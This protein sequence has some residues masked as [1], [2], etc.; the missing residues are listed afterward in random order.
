MATFNHHKTNSVDL[1]ET[2]QNMTP[3]MGLVCWAFHI[4]VF[5]APF[6]GE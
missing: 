1:D 5:A 2:M 3:H 6:N 4:F